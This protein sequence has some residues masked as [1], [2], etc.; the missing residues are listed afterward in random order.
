MLHRTKTSRLGRA[1]TV[2]VVTFG[3]IGPLAAAPMVAAADT[4]V[5][6]N[7]TT[8]A[9]A[10][11][12]GDD[13]LGIASNAQSVFFKIGS[14][15]ATMIAGGLILIGCFERSPKAVLAG[16]AVGAVAF[17]AVNASFL[18]ATQNQAGSLAGEATGSQVK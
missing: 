16:V 17:L 10:K 5:T 14:V 2:V 7:S 3:V 13:W 8:R 12:G 11:D 4:P 6:S 1:C 9:Q 18:Q 15:A